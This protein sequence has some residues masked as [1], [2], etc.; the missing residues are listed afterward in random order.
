MGSPVR[1]QGFRRDLLEVFTFT[2]RGFVLE[3]LFFLRPGLS[4]RHDAGALLPCLHPAQR[5][6]TPPAGSPEGAPRPRLPVPP[7]PAPPPSVLKPAFWLPLLDPLPRAPLPPRPPSD[8]AFDRSNDT[9]PQ[10][11]ALRL[12]PGPGMALVGTCCGQTTYPKPARVLSTKAL[13]IQSDLQAAFVASSG[14]VTAWV[15]KAAGAGAPVEGAEV[16]FFYRDNAGGDEVG[17][18]GV[19]G[20]AAAPGVG[21]LGGG[22]AFNSWVGWCP[23]PGEGLGARVMR[24]LPTSASLRRRT[25]GAP[26]DLPRLTHTH[27][28]P[29][30]LRPAPPPQVRALPGPKCTTGPDG[31]CTVTGESLMQHEAAALVTAP[32]EGPLLVPRVGTALGWSGGRAAHKAVAVLDRPLVRQGDELALTGEGVL[33]GLVG[34]GWEGGVRGRGPAGAAVWMA[35]AKGDGKAGKTESLWSRKCLADPLPTTAHPL[36]TK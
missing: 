26:H 27:P 19:R 25:G 16:A 36:L 18:G 31:T 1:R 22:G 8:A 15:T 20:E 4:P 2:A 7:P 6:P 17:L 28:P 23:M 24:D 11:R 5:A 13:V 34:L 3:E 21:F 12:P 33:G 10:L 30:F 9:S 29:P 32:G 35:G 14:D